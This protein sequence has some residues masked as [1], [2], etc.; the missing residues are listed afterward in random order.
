VRGCRRRTQRRGSRRWWAVADRACM[1]A[2]QG[3]ARGGADAEEGAAR[4]GGDAQ[5]GRG[6]WGRALGGSAVVA[7]NVAGRRI[8]EGGVG[9]CFCQ[10]PPWA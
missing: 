6:G 3:A 8:R 2:R 4:G 7:C 10:R 9:L 5:E 1:K